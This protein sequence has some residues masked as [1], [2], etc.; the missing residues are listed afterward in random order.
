MIVVVL[1]FFVADTIDNAP[2]TF[3]A[4]LGTG[5]LAIVLDA[6][7]RRPLEPQPLTT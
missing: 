5:A 7:F 2:E 1:A 6:L 3:A 4:I